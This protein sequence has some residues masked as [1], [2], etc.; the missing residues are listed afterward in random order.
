MK[1]VFFDI[2]LFA[3]IFLSPWWVTLS[4]SV[5]GLF[6]FAN[7]YEYLISSVIVYV[8]S[9]TPANTLFNNSLLIYSIIIIFY[10]ITQ[11]LRHNIIL[12]KQR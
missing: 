12:Y 7:F 8:V 2:L 11:Y 9:T 4:L 6:I 10:F 1:R 3:C 5:V